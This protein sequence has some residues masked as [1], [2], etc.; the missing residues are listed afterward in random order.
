MTLRRLFSALAVLMLLGCSSPGGGQPAPNPPV[1]HA[2]TPVAEGGLC[3]GF[4][5]FQC[6]S[7][8]VCQ[9]PDGQCHVAD[10]AGTCR[11]PPQACTMIY[12]PVCGC[13]GK[14]YPSACNAAAQGASVASQGECKA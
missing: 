10:G 14:T 4:A 5:G 13:D 1:S 2:R 6:A 7:G 11:K 3:G 9:K 8:L 12:A